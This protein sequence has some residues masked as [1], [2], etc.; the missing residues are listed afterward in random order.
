MLIPGYN[1]FGGQHYETA[2][3]QQALA[4][5]GLTAPH[6]GQ[7]FSEDMLFGL[8]EGLGLT[9]FAFEF[10]QTASIY[11]GT[12]YHLE[13]QRPAIQRLGLKVTVRET[14]SLKGVKRS[15]GC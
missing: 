15:P 8:G 5:A 13:L 1:L 7:P 12:R 14:T 11:I 9:Y 2:P 10:G 4:Y 3:L 6:T